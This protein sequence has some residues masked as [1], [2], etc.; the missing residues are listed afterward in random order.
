MAALQSSG[1]GIKEFKFNEV[2]LRLIAACVLCRS[3]RLFV[4]A[5]LQHTLDKV[6]VDKQRK[7]PWDERLLVQ[8]KIEIGDLDVNDD[9]KRELKFYEMALEATQI[10][11]QHC[12]AA[13]LPLFRPEDYFAEM[14]KTDAHMAKVKNKLLQTKA[15]QAAMEERQKQRHAKKFGKKVQVEKMMERQKAKTKHMDALKQFRKEKS[16]RGDNDVD[17][18]DFLKH[19]DG[20]MSKPS[21]Q[22]RVHCFVLH[23]CDFSDLP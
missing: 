4:Q 23:S 7:L 22:G 6:A 16:G 11:H 15:E 17:G 14:I 19:L 9:L 8:G 10:A 5:A 1:P 12:S 3:I 21:P 18:D 2:R 13:G 20:Q